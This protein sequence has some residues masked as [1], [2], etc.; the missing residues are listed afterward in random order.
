[1]LFSLHCYSL[2][3]KHDWCHLDIYFQAEIS[4]KLNNFLSMLY[5]ILATAF[6]LIVCKN[7]SV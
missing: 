4:L 7:S 1:M 2:H 3:T 5:L 6:M